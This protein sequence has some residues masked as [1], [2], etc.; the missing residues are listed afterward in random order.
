MY[1]ALTLYLQEEPSLY[2]TRQKKGCFNKSKIRKSISTSLCNLITL[3]M[4]LLR[5]ILFLKQK[6]PTEWSRS[7]E[8]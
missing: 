5:S 2:K 3:Q 7:W 1:K 6:I 4:L 8:V